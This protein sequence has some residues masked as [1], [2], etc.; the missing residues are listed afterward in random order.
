MVM[1][2]ARSKSI[3]RNM[4]FTAQVN[5]RANFAL[6]EDLAH[7]SVTRERLMWDRAELRM[8]V[9][10]ACGL[11]G[12]ARLG[13]EGKSLEV[14]PCHGPG[15]TNGQGYF[16]FVTWDGKGSLHVDYAFAVRGSQSLSL[17]PRGGTTRWH[18]A[19]PWPSPSFIG[20]FFRS[21]AVS[22]Q[23]AFRRNGRSASWRWASRHW[24]WKTRGPPWLMHHRMMAAMLRSGHRQ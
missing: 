13:T 4:V 19:A 5:G 12:G 17:V 15:S 24:G 22:R 10:D 14:Q 3:Y 8:G 18:M 6:P 9:S 23:P 21:A 20:V 7:F 16:A 1:P 2:E 11:I